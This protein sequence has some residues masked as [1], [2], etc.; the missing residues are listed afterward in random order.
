MESPLRWLRRFTLILTGLWLLAGCSTGTRLAYNNLDRL[1]AWQVSDY[2]TL[3]PAQKATFDQEF[4]KL[5]DWHR[6]TQLALYAPEL[7]AMASVVD[8]GA[9]TRTTVESFLAKIEQHGEVLGDH[10]REALQPLLPSLTDAQVQMLLDHQRKDIDKEER[11]HADETPDERRKRYVRNVSNNF[12]R[13]IGDLNDE[14]LKR[15]DRTWS[16]GIALLRTP[17]QRR[18]NRLDDLQR[19]ADL[20]A[21]R[22]RPDFNQRLRK[23]WDSDNDP[24]RKATERGRADAAAEALQREMTIDVLTTL[25]AGQRKKLSSQLTSLAEDCDALS[26][27]RVASEA[28]GRP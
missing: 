17:A 8:Q 15:V 20:L 25:E 10:I 4:R 21:E 28:T 3:D 16:Q 12:D 6:Q 2:V 14:Q 24:E 1:A 26:A 19:F 5:W 23:F 11:K 22:R 27:V 18:Q 13:W 9:P 7:R